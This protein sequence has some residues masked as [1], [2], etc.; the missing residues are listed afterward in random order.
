MLALAAQ[1]LSNCAP[2]SPVAPADTVAPTL[3]AAAAP[4]P[5]ATPAPLATATAPKA[6]THLA[7]RAIQEARAVYALEELEIDTDGLVVNRFDPSQ[8]D[9]SVRFT[10][11]SGKVVLV[12]AFSY[13]DF[14]ADSLRLKGGPVWR[15]RFTPTEAGEWQAQAELASPKLSSAPVS[16]EVAPD[17]TAHGFVRINKQNP[18]YLAYDD[19]AFYF[20]IGLN[21]GW[22]TQQNLGVLKDYERWLDRLSQNGG[23][24]ARVWMASWSFGIEWNDTGLG[25]YSGRMKQAWL[26]DQV[27][28]LTEQRHI[29]LMLTLLNHGAFNTSVNPE[30]NDNPYNAAN[31]GPLKEPRLFARNQQARELFKRRVRYIAARWAYSPNLFAWEWWNEVNWTPIDDIALK[32]WIVEMT[33]HLRQYDPNHHLISSSY[34][35]ISSTSLWK[36]PELSFA[37]QHDY[38]G[39]DSAKL[40]PITYRVLAEKAPDK[41]VLLAEMGLDASS[42][43]A[44]RSREVIHF[45]NGIWAAPFSGYAGTG[46]YW[47]WDTFVDP[48]NLWGEY[49]AVAEF[50]KGENLA[51]LAPAKA[52]IAPEGAT[53]LALQGK[54][55]ALV[56]VRSDAYEAAAATQAYQRARQAGPIPSDWQYEPPTLGDLKLTL[57]GLADGSYT[58]RW[59]SPATAEWQ[60]DQTIEVSGG[61][62][63]LA[64]PAFAR[65]LAVKIVAAQAAR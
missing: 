63:T 12:P 23:N 47:W 30:W 2:S 4:A 46:M 25:D 43:D 34:A 6:A 18:R 65:D 10:S 38:S 15:A 32:P 13:Q 17:S 53:A 8:F 49:K 52:Q 64:V 29:Y 37:Q 45:H 56:W 48:R 1:L 19:G 40:L 31:G 9:L 42:A 24:I 26:L 14:D 20:P 50:L 36:M 7:L 39:N 41:P 11:P 55:R 22:A 27:F 51:P 61:V 54:D 5:S 62:T 44:Q 33:A 57:T 16:F 21:L 58:V 59:F 35:G 60:V 28:K 3:A